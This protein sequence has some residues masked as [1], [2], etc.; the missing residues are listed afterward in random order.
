MRLGEGLQEYIEHGATD[1]YYPSGLKALDDLILGAIAGELTLVAGAPNGGKSVLV[2]QWLLHNAARGI[3]AA[4][5]SLEMSRFGLG[6]RLLSGLAG[7]PISRLRKRDF[8]DGEQERLRAAAGKL[9]ALEVE[10]CEAGGWKSDTIGQGITALAKAGAKLV[11]VDYLQMIGGKSGSR[12][13][14]VGEAC[15]NCKEAAKEA[16]VAVLLVSSLNRASAY[17]E[18]RKPRLSDLRDSGDIEYACDTICAITN[19]DEGDEFS[20]TRLAEIHVLKLRNGQ[21]GIA[22]AKIVKS[23]SRFLDL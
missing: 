17:R 23:R 11:A 18:T 20:D 21:L 8:R 16:N 15:R 19:P 22:A 10:V 4:V 5:V 6:Q 12:N 13:T 3:P 7:V 9:A 2:L 1:V 14:D